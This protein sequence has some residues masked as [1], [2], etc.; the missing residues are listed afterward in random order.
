MGLSS[1]GEYMKVVKC[2]GHQGDVAIFQVDEFPEGARVQ[3]D[4]TKN[5]Q[6]AL[7]ELSGHNHAFEDATAVD[8]FKINTPEYQ[9]LTFIQT[10]KPA[11]LVHGL[12]K[13]FKGREA[14]QDY[15]SEITLKEGKKY[16]TGIV[17]ETDWT[18]RTIRKVID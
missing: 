12:I 2:V 15:H 4:L 10:K 14:D 17:E 9:G 11:K 7:G 18:T 5:Q 8:L 6:L 3:D 1:I 13:G 16:I